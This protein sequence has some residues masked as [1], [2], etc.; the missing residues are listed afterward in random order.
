MKYTLM[1]L[2]LCLGV[3]A[4]GQTDSLNNAEWFRLKAEKL[5]RLEQVNA[6]TEILGASQ[7]AQKLENVPASV[8]VVNQKQ[9]KENGYH[10]LSDLLKDLPGFDV[11]ENA[12]RELKNG[13]EIVKNYQSPMSLPNLS[14]I[15]IYL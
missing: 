4:R 14:M 13:Y 6:E 8:I 10:D 7:Y 3:G 1:L 15:I 9:M 11:I 12:G 5:I 2:L